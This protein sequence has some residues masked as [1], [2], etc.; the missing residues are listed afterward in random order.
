[1][2]VEHEMH[3]LTYVRI[4]TLGGNSQ[5]E[6]LTYTFARARGPPWEPIQPLHDTVRATT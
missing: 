4:L 1:M 2:T 3:P 6:L 5:G